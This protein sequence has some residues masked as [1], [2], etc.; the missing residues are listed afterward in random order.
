MSE[1][2]SFVSPCHFGLESVLKREVSD[3]GLAIDRVEDGKVYYSGSQRDLAR[4][5]VFLRTTERVLVIVGEFTAV[6]F[7][8]LFEKTKALPWGVYLPRDA[9]TWVAKANSI[10][11]ALFSPSDIQSIVKKAIVE[12]LKSAYRTDV[13]PETGHPYPIRI[14]ILKDRVTMALDS[15]GESLHKRGYRVNTVPAP[16]T[17]TLA[18]ALILSTP[19]KEDRVFFDG[20]AGSGT[21]PIEAAMIGRHIAPGLDREFTAENWTNLVSKRDW[22]EAS[23]EALDLQKSGAHLAIYASDIDRRAIA[24]ATENAKRA[25]VADTITFRTEDISAVALPESYGF[26]ISNPPYGER[27]SDKEELPK[28]YSEIGRTFERL[29]KWSLYLITAFDAAE[30]YVGR[31]ADKNRKIYNGM[32]KTYF[33]SFLGPK[34]ERGEKQSENPV[35]DGK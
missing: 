11:S 5:N 26:W 17:E 33:Y 9:R 27:I 30:S 28:L 16:I 31:K 29:D 35:C 6:T 22:Y 14:S 2:F 4:A 25:N 3:L 10:K 34:P 1:T 23:K 32:M 19:W 18:A 15:S 13:V 7:D 8:E 12:R 20:F 21:F 24:A